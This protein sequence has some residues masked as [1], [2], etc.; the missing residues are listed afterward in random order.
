MTKDERA[1]RE[2]DE[3]KLTV[4]LQHARNWKK[5]LYLNMGI[6]GSEWLEVVKHSLA[7]ISEQVSNGNECYQYQEGRVPQH[8]GVLHC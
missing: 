7:Y 1:Y 2:M 4:L 8:I 5:V 6:V 3:T